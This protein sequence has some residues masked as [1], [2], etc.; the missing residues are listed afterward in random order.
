MRKSTKERY[1]AIY[2]PIEAE[3]VYQDEMRRIASRKRIALGLMLF[4]LCGLLLLFL[5]TVLSMLNTKHDSATNAQMTKT[6]SAVER[7]VEQVEPPAKQINDVSTVAKAEIGEQPSEATGAAPDEVITESSPEAEMSDDDMK[8]LNAIG[9]IDVDKGLFNVT[10]TLPKDFIGDVTQE[11]LDEYA[12]ERGYK[13]ATLNS[14]GSVTLKLTKAQ[15]EEILAET[16]AS[17]DDSLAKMIG[18]PET[19]NITD[20]KAND[21]YTVFTITTKNT[22]LDFGEAFLVLSLYASGGMYGIF[23]G[24][25]VDN[26]RVDYVNAE[27]GEIISS[28]NSKDMGANQ[29]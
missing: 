19:P 10:M 16:R 9:D 27:T 8:G 5:I 1:R 26:I 21:N 11:Y 7:Q 29:E 12:A 4:S 24:E 25:D 13:S 3:Q 15:H 23:S 18:S 20:I 2:D 6:P 17:I 14:D 22:E 28:A